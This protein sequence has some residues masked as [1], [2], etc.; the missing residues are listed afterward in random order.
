MGCFVFVIIFALSPFLCLC[1]EQMP[2]IV[3]SD[4]VY[5]EQ[6]GAGGAVCVVPAMYGDYNKLTLVLEALG[7]IKLNSQI[8]ECTTKTNCVQWGTQYPPC[9]AIVFLGDYI[10]PENF[11]RP[12][13]KVVQLVKGMQM[14]APE[15]I[16]VIA[17]RGHL[18]SLLDKD[19]VNEG[20]LWDG[21]SCQTDLGEFLC[22]LPKACRI[23]QWLFTNSEVA[24]NWFKLVDQKIFNF[25]THPFKE[26]LASEKEPETV[27]N[28]M[29]YDALND[30]NQIVYMGLNNTVKHICQGRDHGQNRVSQRYGFSF[31]IFPGRN[32][33]GSMTMMRVEEDNSLDVVT[34]CLDT[35]EGGVFNPRTDG[36]WN[37]KY[38]NTRTI[39]C[40]PCAYPKVKRPMDIDMEVLTE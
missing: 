15:N 27:S 33:C 17:L 34:L 19:R 26:Y 25:R 20:E 24:N 40:G 22:S 39:N 28:D 5:H 4:P 12:S 11:G 37:S 2:H 16:Q 32:S 9:Q 7:V 38:N 35:V 8:G 18:E 31:Q 13:R 3:V 29:W 6:E 1:N 14:S 10:D 36:L 23:F 21:R 30:K